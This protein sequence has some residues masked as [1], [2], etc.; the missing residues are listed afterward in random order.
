MK[1][2]KTV[3]SLILAVVSLL[4]L[5]PASF[6]AGAFT[7]ATEHW[8]GAEISRW[9]DRG[10]I[11]GSGGLFR[12]NDLITRAELAAIL[13]RVMSYQ[14]IADNTFTDLPEKWYTKDILALNAAGVMQG[15]NGNVR[16][17]DNITREEASVMFGRAFRVDEGTSASTRFFD[18]GTISSWAQPLVFGMEAKGYVSGSSGQFRPRDHISRAEVVKILDNLIDVYIT[19]AG[20]NTGDVEGNVL[21]NTIGVTL[22]N[23]NIA[24]DLYLS[25]GIAEGDVNLDSVTV[26]GKT[27]VYGGGM[28][29]INIGGK[30]SFTAMEICKPSE[31]VH[32]RVTGDAVTFFLDLGKIDGL[33]VTEGKDGELDVVVSGNMILRP[34]TE[35]TPESMPPV[36]SPP[37]GSG[38][39]GSGSGGGGSGD[40][41]SPSYRS[42]NVQNIS[43]P[44]GMQPGDIGLPSAVILTANTGATSTASVAWDFSSYNPVVAGAY[45][46]TG[47]LSNASISWVPISISVTVTVL[48]AVG[49]GDNPKQKLTSPQNIVISFAY[50]WPDVRWDKVANAKGYQLTLTDSEGTNVSVD[51]DDPDAASHSFKSVT[52][53]K[54][55]SYTV[56]VVALSGESPLYTDSEAAT[57]SKD[58]Y[59]RLLVIYPAPR[60]NIEITADGLISASWSAAKN[61]QAVYWVEI[62]G[63]EYQLG[64]ELL[65]SVLTS[66]LSILCPIKADVYGEYTVSVA[67]FAGDNG[68]INS[69]PFTDSFFWWDRAKFE[70]N[71]YLGDVTGDPL[72][73]HSGTAYI[74]ASWDPPGHSLGQLKAM[75]YVTQQQLGEYDNTGIQK[76]KTGNYILPDGLDD[77]VNNRVDIVFPF[78]I[79]FENTLTAAKIALNFETIR[80]TNTYE[81]GILTNLTSLPTSLP[82]YPG[83][84][85]AWASSQ[86]AIV[87]A[88]G[89]VTRPADTA[90]DAEVTLTATLTYSGATE[91]K[92]FDLIVRKQGIAEISLNGVDPRFA[93]GYP[94]VIFDEENFATLKI[95]LNPGVA[96]AEHPVVAYFV[97]DNQGIQGYDILDKDSILYGH[98]NSTDG[99]IYQ[100]SIVDE[101]F[102]ETDT[103][104]SFHSYDEFLRDGYVTNTG[105]VLLADDNLNDSNARATVFSA[106]TD[107]NDFFHFGSEAI[108]NI[109]G[110]KIYLYFDTKL[111]NTIDDLPLASDF[112]ITG[113]SDVTVTDLDIGHNPEMGTNDRHASWLILTLSRSI[114]IDAPYNVQLTYTDSYD[115]PGH[116]IP[117]HALHANGTYLIAFTRWPIS[118]TQSVSAYINPEFG[119]LSLVFRPALQMSLENPQAFLNH[120][121]SSLRYKNTPILAECVAPEYLVAPSQR[122]VDHCDL[123]FAFDPILGDDLTSDDF[124]LTLASDLISVTF[125]PFLSLQPSISVLSFEN[126]E[127]SSASYIDSFAGSILVRLPSDVNLQGYLGNAT[128]PACNFILKVDGERV[129][130]RGYTHALVPN[131]F[132][133]P[134]LSERLTERLFHANSV[135]LEYNPTV[136]GHDD[137]DS[138]L[139]DCSWVYVPNFG[140]IPV[141]IPDIDHALSPEG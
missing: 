91:T 35:E 99:H 45:I 17:E 27:V 107:D 83:V 21:I 109:S 31:P 129:L 43:V 79:N 89:V 118:G 126:I 133:L 36:A 56:S 52:A 135:T 4:G 16:P 113:V 50:G 39:G 61:D 138:M 24:S 64:D 60:S 30:S 74:G 112:K 124:T 54:D 90:A 15:A 93:P 22:K 3:L 110:E 77:Q 11:L 46:I 34:N 102:I 8:A 140:P 127:D 116:A 88:T 68:G 7:D 94:K 86:S 1:L 12:P 53:Y 136:S 10:I 128:I 13:N 19:E 121:I 47:T 69:F 105:I 26:K 20:E 25:D 85:I 139:V 78:L 131:A 103:E 2:L 100:A 48:E 6:A 122:A 40:G 37:G 123:L 66:D 125:D 130:L 71:Y 81:Q 87:S 63:P 95:K 65:Y 141:D 42:H 97:M 51:V 114:T 33:T 28:D 32:I 108:L 55:V 70:I 76:N 67:L 117:E 134:L 106:A 72:Y 104:Y 44:F 58:C 57:A 18:A 80:G 96:S 120:I 38:S 84:S 101:L 75:G 132:I 82:A 5:F 59:G 29:S 137:P 49:S 115:D 62:T 14:Q 9:S 73:T 119:R 92:T 23:M 98:V 111:D 41:G